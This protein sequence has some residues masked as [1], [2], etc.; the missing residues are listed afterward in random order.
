MEIFV[1]GVS[2]KNVTPDEVVANIFFKASGKTQEEAI[3]KGLNNVTTFTNLVLIGSGLP[4]DSLKTQNFSISE[5]RVYNEESRRH[6]VVGYVFNQ[7]ATLKMDYNNELL[8][9]FLSLTS[10]L[11]NAPEINFQFGL[12]EEDKYTN[13]L[14]DEAYRDAERKARMLA[15]AAGRNLD[16]SIMLELKSDSNMQMFRSQS[17]F[18][19]GIL[20]TM[21]INNIDTS[22]IHPE[23]IKVEVRIATKWEAN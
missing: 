4:S 7:F 17:S 21:S 23:D 8:S 12:K 3:Q 6:E 18:D 11:E 16:D 9:K 14:I 13:E 5:D 2:N 22:Y 15:D 1:E 19:S 20:K 10:S